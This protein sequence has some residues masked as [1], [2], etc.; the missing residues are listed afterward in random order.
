MGIVAQ[1]LAYSFLASGVPFLGSAAAM[2]FIFIPSDTTLTA[3]AAAANITDLL[4]MASFSASSTW[5]LALEEEEEEAFTA[6]IIPATLCCWA[7]ALGLEASFMPARLDDADDS[8]QGAET[9][10]AAI[11]TQ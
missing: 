4:C 7:P 6:G 10:R 11:S 3:A 9:V 2:A 1:I 8:L 5:M